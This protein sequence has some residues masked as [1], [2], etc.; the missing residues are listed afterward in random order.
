MK[1]LELKQGLGLTIFDIDDTL[2]HTTAE[3]KVVKNGKIVRSL[4]NQEFNNY[5]LQP[6]ESFDFGEF[7]D[8]EKFNQESRPIRP[9]I[10]KLKAMLKMPVT[11]KL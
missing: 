5:E 7:R 9:M 4:N 8:A 2:F 6:G 11:V 1:L 3:I 10:A